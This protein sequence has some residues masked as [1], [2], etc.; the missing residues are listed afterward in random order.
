MLHVHIFTLFRFFFPIQVITEHSVE[1][2][3]LYIRSLVVIYF[4]SSSIYVSLNL[5]KQYQENLILYLSIL[6]D[7]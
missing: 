7:E 2:P 5:S 3:E 1:F 4:I 6:S